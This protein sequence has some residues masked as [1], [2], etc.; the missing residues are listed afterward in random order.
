MTTTYTGYID[1]TLLFGG[2][3]NQQYRLLTGQI[4]TELNAADQFNFTLPSDN[5]ML[6]SIAPRKS[7]VDVYKNGDL[8]FRGTVDGIEKNFDG[9]RAYTA[10][11]M[12]A[13]LKDALITPM[14]DVTV[15]AALTA[16]LT[17]HNSVVGNS[18]YQ[19]TLGTVEP[20]GTVTIGDAD[21]DW[22]LSA[23]DALS[24]LLAAK[25]GYIR[26]RYAP[27]AVYLDYLNT[28]TRNDSQRIDLS[29]LID[30]SE[31]INTDSIVSRVY[32][33]G[34]DGITISSVNGGS[35]YLVNEA[36]EHKYGCVERTYISD[37]IETPAA[38]KS[39][40]QAY[41]TRYAAEKNVISLTAVDLSLI[42]RAAAAFEVGQIVRVISVPHGIDAE[43]VIHAVL[44]DL[45]QPSNSRVTLGGAQ[46]TLTRAMSG[47]VEAEANS[48]GNAA[49]CVIDSELS[50]TS[51]NPVQN[52]AVK[53]EL[54]KKADK[55]ALDNKFD[56]AGGTL[57][58]NLTG[59]YLT[60]TWL[61]TTQASDLNS[62]PSKIAVLDGSGWVY[63]RT[64]AELASDIGVVAPAD[65]IVEKGTSSGWQYRKWNS[66]VA[67]CWR[68]LSVNG[69]ACSTA[70]GSWFRTAKL[71]VGAYPFTFTAAPNLQMQFETFAG[72]GGLV[73]STGTAG[74][75]PTTRPAN[76]YII[77]MSSAASIT[78]TVHYYAIGKWK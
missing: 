71:S 49:E 68:D 35:D 25:G 26:L 75:T 55:T 1:G 46:S 43:M 72:T 20:T 65:H 76:I 38:L 4:S 30:I 74:S 62:K 13:L 50:G 60:G 15:S 56:K 28:H 12:L 44:S 6:G 51:T 36:V 5:P 32:A 78:G 67:E 48:A 73:W 64:P 14:Q 54:D 24:A 9:S 17:K 63:Y 70:V 57:T 45:V 66:G 52:K 16:M 29:N 8:I 2:V 40:A 59:Q 3:G 39:A 58:G 27:N 61:Q 34:K 10:V 42:D 18:A 41:L 69:K 33:R 19:I 23:G 77:R 22:M 37:E 31:Q 7:I 53:T 47:S 11:G 21:K